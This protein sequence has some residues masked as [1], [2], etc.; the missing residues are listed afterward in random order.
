MLKA[1]NGVCEICGKP[2]PKLRPLFVD[3][4][5]T[6]LKVRGLLC[7]KCNT[8]LGWYESVVGAKVEEYLAKQ[9]G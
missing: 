3:H 9:K 1:C 7:M 2:D 8:G 5:H 4:C 6:T